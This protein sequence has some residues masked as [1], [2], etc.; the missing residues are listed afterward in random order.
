MFAIDDSASIFCARVMRG[1]WSIAMAWTFRAARRSMSALFF[2][3]HRKLMSMEP[4]FS[5]SASS[6]VGGCTLSR[7]SAVDQSAAV[8]GTTVAPA[9]T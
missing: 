1:I 7:R 6:G 8:S 5:R 4:G 9:F 2:T 3:G